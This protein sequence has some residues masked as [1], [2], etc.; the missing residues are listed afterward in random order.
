[1][2]TGIVGLVLC[3]IPF[4][5]GLIALVGAVLSGIA[6][7]MARRRNQGIGMAIAGLV[8]GVLGVIFG[9]IIV[10]AIVASYDPY[11]YY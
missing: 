10:I 3:W 8:C 5:G 9:I 2:I 1:M 7:P 6:I 4:L 11:Y